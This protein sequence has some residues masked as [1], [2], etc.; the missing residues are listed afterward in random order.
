MQQSVVLGLASP[1]IQEPDAERRLWPAGAAGSGHRSGQAEG[2]LQGTRDEEDQGRAEQDEA[3]ADE[4]VDVHHTTYVCGRVRA[5]ESFG[6]LGYAVGMVDTPT[7]QQKANPMKQIAV[8]MVVLGLSLASILWGCSAKPSA[9]VAVAPPSEVDSAK[10]KAPD[11]KAATTNSIGMKFVLIPAGKFL[12]GSPN[13]DETAED[14]EKPQH[15]VEITKPFYL[16]VY[17]VTQA[18]YEQVVGSNPSHFKGDMRQPVENVSWFDAVAFCNRLSERERILPYYKVDGET[19]SIIGGN[20][21][22]LPTEAE[23]EYACRAG[24]TTKWNFGDDES[25]LGDC[26]WYYGNSGE[27]PHRVGE[28]KPN[29]WG[30]YDMHGNVWEWCWDWFDIQTY[31]AEFV[32]DPMGP[33]NSSVKCRVLRGG[34]FFR[35]P[36]ILRSADRDGDR[37]GNRSYLIGFRPARTYN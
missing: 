16:S 32:R 26:A 19:V 2:H 22:R 1:L 35:Q 33:P 31:E 34:G 9:E 3:V 18:E 25:K 12:M 5:I 29:L 7:A 15:P 23:W 36:W 4:G 10:T 28:K 27:K 11:N 21:Y 17:E 13:S 30:L 14:S 8:P 20:G 37:P 24:T 6:G